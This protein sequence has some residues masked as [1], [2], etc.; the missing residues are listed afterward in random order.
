MS[1]LGASCV[2]LVVMVALVSGAMPV[3]AAPT[4]G[5][6]GRVESV[7]G[8]PLAG[9]EV[10]LLAATQARALIARS[11]SDTTGGFYID[12]IPPG[13]YFVQALLE[14]HATTV[15]PID[16]RTDE[17]VQLVLEPRTIPDPGAHSAAW[18]LRAPRRSLWHELGKGVSLGADDASARAPD[19]QQSGVRLD[20]WF[21]VHAPAQDTEAATALNASETRLSG[22]ARLTD[23]IELSGAAR[24]SRIDADGAPSPGGR[25][26]AMATRSFGVVGEITAGRQDRLHVS[27]DYSQRSW[28][29]APGPV[30]G[31]HSNEVGGLVGQMD[32]VRRLGATGEFELH[33]SSRSMDLA[34]RP[35]AAEGGSAD[36]IDRVRQA[37]A[38]RSI[39]MGGRYVRTLG[40]DHQLRMS[41]GAARRDWDFTAQQASGLQAGGAG[42]ELHLAEHWAPSPEWEL[43][44]GLGYVDSAGPDAPHYWVPRGG[45]TWSDGP[46]RVSAEVAYH[47]QV[48]S[49]PAVTANDRWEP[50]RR[51]SHHVEFDLGISESLRLVAGSHYEPLAAELGAAQ[52]PVDAI[53]TGRHP[54]VADAQLEQELHHAELLAELAGAHVW[55]RLASGR[56]VGWLVPY[57]ALSSIELAQ[58]DLRFAEARLGVNI[59]GSGTELEIAWRRVS[60]ARDGD[61][62]VSARDVAFEVNIEQSLP[63]PLRRGDWRLLAGLHL[64]ES[65]GERG[66]PGVLDPLGRRVRA[67]LSV[68][69]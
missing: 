20:Q 61:G 9:A 16:T 46:W 2:R 48:N 66:E 34:E 52:T 53:E 25:S 22:V 54:F 5:V 36:R 30:A 32:W 13:T 31:V 58:R 11:R 63:A 23:E 10:L 45:A 27:A 42:W 64:G 50:R 28:S 40:A 26:V 1:V 29:A 44:G 47:D 67:G 12:A 17:Q 4:T 19:L 60:E 7:T 62:A 68:A 38:A 21:S 51:L 57:T 65:R 43:A 41:W 69:F 59:E 14:G 56:A 24:R 49:P 55:F 37:T 3:A 39:H 6:A 18:A 8:A 33:L 35:A 15:R